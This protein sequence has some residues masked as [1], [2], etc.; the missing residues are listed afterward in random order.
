MVST[1]VSIAFSEPHPAEPHVWPSVY[2]LH[3]A[4]HPGDGD[5]HAWIQPARNPTANPHPARVGTRRRAENPPSGPKTCSARVS[6]SGCSASGCIPLDLPLV[7]IPPRTLVFRVE[8]LGVYCRSGA[9]GKRTR[10]ILVPAWIP[11]HSGLRAHRNRAD[12][13]LQQSVRH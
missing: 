9:A 4:A 12:R 13:G 11:H 10:G 7:A 1:V 5:F 2:D 6:A 3:S 8:I